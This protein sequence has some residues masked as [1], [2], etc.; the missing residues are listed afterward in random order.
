MD[1]VQ[2]YSRLDQEAKKSLQ[3]Y[4]ISIGLPAVAE[5]QRPVNVQQIGD[6]VDSLAYE[7][8]GKP[9]DIFV[10]G[11][12]RPVRQ[13]WRN[14][15]GFAA[16]ETSVRKANPA[17]RSIHA[18]DFVERLSS[19]SP[20]QQYI[21]RFFY[22]WIQRL[23]EGL[24]SRV[25]FF[26]GFEAGRLSG[27]NHFHALLAANGIRDQMAHEAELLRRCREIGRSV[28][29]FAQ[30]ESLLLWGHLYQ[31]AGR[32]LI[33]PFDPG[34]GAGWYV[35]AAYVGKTQLGWDVSVGEP[36]IVPDDPTERGGTGRDLIK[37]P[38]LPRDFYHNT[39][40]RWHR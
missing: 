21:E 35:A 8:L 14:P 13:R 36:T 18:S 4:R 9:W 26:V 19:H 11:T 32:S 12:F 7:R 5:F 16:V 40:T 20:S 3:N 2:I 23:G 39:L 34:R 10:T 6:W 27:A 1:R 28:Q 24:S 37:S 17:S 15:R 30:N 33:L 29:E 38:E 31:T 22:S 25:D